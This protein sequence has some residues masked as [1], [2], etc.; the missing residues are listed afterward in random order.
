MCVLFTLHHSSFIIKDTLL[1]KALFNLYL[2]DKLLTDTG[3]YVILAKTRNLCLGK[4][5]KTSYLE[6]LVQEVTSNQHHRTRA[7]VRYLR[8]DRGYRLDWGCWCGYWLQHSEVPGCW[9]CS[10]PDSCLSE[11]SCPGCPSSSGWRLALG[12]TAAP[13]TE[14][15]KWTRSSKSPLWTLAPVTHLQTNKCLWYFNAVTFADYF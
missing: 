2:T 11:Y 3:F 8:Y 13:E 15:T 5:K 7:C 12:W 4:T 6:T 10:T 9:V 14:M 1:Y